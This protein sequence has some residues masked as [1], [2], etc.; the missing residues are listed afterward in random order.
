MS[1]FLTPPRRALA[2]GAIAVALAAA[3]VVVALGGCAGGSTK[4]NVAL[5]PTRS[6]PLTTIFEA[7]NELSTN[8]GPTLDLLKRLGV[9]DVKVFMPWGYL[10][11]DALS[12]KR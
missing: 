8:P 4:E 6:V 2:L 5:A 3:C 12:H 11:P 1:P 9:D 7:Q 10:A